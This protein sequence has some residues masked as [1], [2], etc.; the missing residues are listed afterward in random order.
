MA[1]MRRFPRG[2]TTAAAFC[3]LI[4]TSSAAGQDKPVVPVHQEP[5]HRMV[6]ESPGIRILDVQIPP[7]DT[8]LFHTH[9][10]PILYVTM[11]SSTTRTQT[12]GGSWNGTPAPGPASS[13]PFR[14]APSSPPGRMM[15]TTTYAER[16]LTHR[17]S[18]VGDTLFRLIATTNASPG[19]E[20]TGPSS[21]FA[22]TPEITN[23]WFRGYRV[24]AGADG[25][26]EHRHAN[27]VNL[28]LV[29]G[30][31]SA[32]IGETTRAFD[33]LGQFAFI[34]PGVPHR[35]AGVGGEAQLVEVEVRRPLK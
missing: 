10:D 11:R 6:F 31:A 18:N 8:T 29:S 7:G 3:V 20:S 5:R 9:S 28:V 25:G 22:G 13:S 21:G 34:E 16:A 4:G 24:I 32:T 15:S 35:I 23:R 26:T 33:L 14:L 17:V 12:L 30:R 19:D 2:P 1:R 27:P